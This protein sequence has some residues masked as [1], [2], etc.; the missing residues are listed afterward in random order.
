MSAAEDV[1][2]ELRSKEFNKAIENYSRED[3]NA[4]S[5]IENRQQEIMDSAVNNERKFRAFDGVLAALHN[6]FP[7]SNT[8]YCQA[9]EKQLTYVNK[10]NSEDL[11]RI[12]KDAYFHSHDVDVMLYG[13]VIYGAYKLSKDKENF[14]YKDIAKYFRKKQLQQERKAIREDIKER[15]RELD[16]YLEDSQTDAVRKLGMVD[17]ILD[18]VQDKYFG[19]IEANKV[20]R[21]YCKAAVQICR[22]ELFDTNSADRYLMY[23]N[24]YARRADKAD[25]EWEK[26][27]GDP[28]KAK[29]KENLYMK[30]YRSDTGR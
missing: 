18:I 9:L 17:E 6:I 12:A 5:F 25:L 27:H 30:N 28:Q 24:E 16:F 14:P 15:V 13:K 11:E 8:A 4:W 2:F 29:I 10:K 22:E 26:R 1:R 20:K 3:E 21:N 19:P 7:R 23:A